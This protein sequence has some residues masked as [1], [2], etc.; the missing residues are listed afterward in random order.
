MIIIETCPKCG[1]D[2]HDVMLATYPPIPKK[3]CWSCG[4]SWTGEPEEVIRMPFGGNSLIKDDL[5]GL[6]DYTV[7]NAVDVDI[8]DDNV[9]H[10]GPIHINNNE[11][12]S[13]LGNF[14]QPACISCSNNPKNSGNGICSCILG[15]TDIT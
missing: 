15:Q 12:Y 2:L 1:H 11:L 8:H 13:T 14:E 3:E 5:V 4:W 6:E 9:V 10:V 7:L